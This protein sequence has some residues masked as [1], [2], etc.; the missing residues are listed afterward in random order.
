MAD[1]TL[2]RSPYGLGVLADVAAQFT[3]VLPHPPALAAPSSHSAEEAGG[4]TP[5][6]VAE[7][8]VAES[9][10]APRRVPLFVG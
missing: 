2:N 9:N 5:T 7:R 6:G 10:G 1:V 8:P 4:A 3:D